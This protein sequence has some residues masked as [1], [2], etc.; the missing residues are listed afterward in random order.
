L[1]F[2]CGDAFFL[3]LAHALDLAHPFFPIGNEL[4]SVPLF[5]ATV[6]AATF[7][8]GYLRLYTGSV[9]SASLAHA[10]HNAA[11]GVLG[12]FTLT[13]YDPDPEAANVGAHR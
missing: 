4:I 6:V 3:H 13:S 8:Y 7:V 11:W 10:V 9:W 1:A 5:Y 2:R 12:A